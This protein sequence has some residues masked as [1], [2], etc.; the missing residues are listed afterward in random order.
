MANGTFFAFNSSSALDI[1]LKP[2]IG[3]ITLRCYNEDKVLLPVVMESAPDRTALLT[4][5]PSILLDLNVACDSWKYNLLS[6]FSKQVSSIVTWELDPQL[7]ISWR[8]SSHESL[9]LWSFLNV[10]QLQQGGKIVCWVFLCI[11][12]S[13]YIDMC[14]QV[15]Y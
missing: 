3:L 4:L 6:R 8:M 7:S 1:A 2:L 11:R 9:F 12:Q 15:I 5:Q 10:M 14:F 13:L